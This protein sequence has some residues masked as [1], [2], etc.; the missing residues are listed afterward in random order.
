MLFSRFKQHSLLIAGVA[1]VLCAGSLTGCGTLQKVFADPA[2]VQDIVGGVVAI[3]EDTGTPE[4]TINAQMSKALAVAS[5]TTMTI[6]QVQ[7]SLQA[8]PGIGPAVSTWLQDNPEFTQTQATL[9]TWLKAFVA[10]TTPL[11]VQRANVQLRLQSRRARKSLGVS[12]V[13]PL[14]GVDANGLALCEPGVA[15]SSLQALPALG[16]PL[17][18]QRACEVPFS[19][20]G[21]TT[22]SSPLIVFRPLVE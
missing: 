20:G 9:T 1:I 15:C 6:A 13:G 3:W 8:I 12:D 19:C 4:A 18:L 16:A 10:A 11:T 14:H 7:A 2:V 17:V 22:W 5:S 21:T